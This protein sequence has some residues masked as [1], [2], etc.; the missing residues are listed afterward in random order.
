MR[1]ILNLLLFS[2]ALFLLTL[3]CGNDKKSPTGPDDNPHDISGINFIAIPGGTFRMGD[4]SG[5]GNE[6]DLPVHNIQLSGFEMSIY[7][8]TN[9]QY[10]AY[11]N[12]ALES[13]R[14]S[15]TSRSVT[16][17]TGDW[18]DQKYAELDDSH[19]DIDFSEGAFAVREGRENN[20]VYEVTWFGAKAFVEYYGFN[21]PTEAEWEYAC[22]AGTE[23]IFYTG[24]R[25]SYDGNKSSFD[26]DDAGWY[27][28]NSDDDTHPVGLKVP[29]DFGLFD[30]H[31]NVLEWCSDWYGES[32][33]SSSPSKNPTGPDSGSDRILR[34]GGC[35]NFAYVCTSALHIG[36]PPE[37][38]QRDVGFRVVRRP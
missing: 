11:L 37:A 15:A 36:F 26:L 31:G 8:V 21:L 33:Y 34:G 23:S 1:N 24:S 13:G 14:I 25:L 6:Y 17:K 19:S 28:D 35:R 16:G 38:S 2:L 9:S 29:N 30:M 18:K 10:A 27:R 12:E 32:Y 3:S 7:E 20:P 22:R 4:I 5:K